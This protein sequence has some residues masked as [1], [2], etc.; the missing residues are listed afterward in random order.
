MN[1]EYLELISLDVWHIAAAILNLLILVWIMKKFLIGPVQ[2]ILAERQSQVDTLYSN[3]ETAK[4]AAE[5]DRA[6]YEE[7]MAN[8]D[9]EAEEVVRRATVRAD[10]ISDEILAEAN[11]KAAEKLRKADADIEQEKKKAI[12]EIKD[13]ISGMSMDIAEAVVCREI[14]ASDH[15][16]LIDTFIDSL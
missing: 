13:E 10:K 2:K 15:E 8:A 14:K 3:A 4:N 7:K 6:V 16:K 9:K 12:N 11:R 1:R 5:A